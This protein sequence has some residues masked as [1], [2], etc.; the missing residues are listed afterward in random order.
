LG[1]KGTDFVLKSEKKQL[2]LFQIPSILFLHNALLNNEL[3][4]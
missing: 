2:L 1:C 4:K 3:E